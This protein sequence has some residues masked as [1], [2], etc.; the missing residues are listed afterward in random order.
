MQR[1]PLVKECNHKKGGGGSDEEIE[2]NRLSLKINE[3]TK[4]KSKT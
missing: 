3:T 1:K 4:S 2:G